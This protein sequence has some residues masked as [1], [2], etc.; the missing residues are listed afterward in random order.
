MHNAVR[1]QRS[2]NVKL[3]LTPATSAS[4]SDNRGGGSRR[5]PSRHGESL[6]EEHIILFVHMLMHV[7]LET[8]ESII[9]RAKGVTGP[10]R[11]RVVIRQLLELLKCGP[12]FL[13]LGLQLLEFFGEP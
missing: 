10:F 11:R 6:W 1:S 5:F 8:R 4:D 12:G 2:R 9:E 13:V 3:H 7:L